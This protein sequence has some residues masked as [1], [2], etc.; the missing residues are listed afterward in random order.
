MR[1]LVLLQVFREFGRGGHGQFLRQEQA[2]AATAG[3]R[4]GGLNFC[5]F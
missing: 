4:A 5:D 2:E 3:R 1:F